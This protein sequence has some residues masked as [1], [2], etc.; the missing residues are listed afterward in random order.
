MR[1]FTKSILALISLIYLV[2][3][4]SDPTN[5]IG[6]EV[7]PPVVT[8]TPLDAEQTSLQFLLDFT[9]EHDQG[10]VVDVEILVLAPGSTWISMGVFTESPATYHAADP[11]LHKFMA[12]AHDPDGNTQEMPSLAQAETMVPEPIIITDLQGEDF[13][14]TNAVLRHNMTLRGWDHGLGRNAIRPI[15]DPQFV[16]PGEA[17]YPRDNDTSTVMAMDLQN[18]FRAYALHDLNDKEV[19]NDAIGDVYFAATF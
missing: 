9:I 18:D 8:I 16:L 6:P 14:I 2:G 15:N 13:D 19:V 11:G 5:T 12:L 3:C 17:G 10:G 1:P 4:Q 7:V